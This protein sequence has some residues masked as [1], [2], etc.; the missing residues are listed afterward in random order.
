[1]VDLCRIK[2]FVVTKNGRL[3]FG[4]PDTKDKVQIILHHKI[5]PEVYQE[6][7]EYIE[8]LNR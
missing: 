5:N 3:M 1:V 6:V 7:L 4:L 2:S 8:K